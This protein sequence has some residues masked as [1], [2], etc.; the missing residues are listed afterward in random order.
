M[1]RF[2][3]FTAGVLSLFSCEK[4]ND[5]TTDYDYSAV[6]FAHQNQLRTVVAAEP[7]SFEFGVY[8]AGKR[9]NANEEWAKYRIEPELLEDRKIVGDRNFELIPEDCYT[10]SSPDIFN[11]HEGSFLGTSKITFDIEKFT[12]LPGTDEV[13]YALPVRVYETSADSIL[14]GKTSPEGSIIVA[15]MD[16]A[17]IAVRYINPYHGNYYIKGTRYIEEGE[18][19]KVDETYDQR[20]LSKNKVISVSTEDLHTSVT[21]V[22]G[23]MSSSGGVAVGLSIYVSD[24]SE[25]FLSKFADASSIL[26]FNDLGSSYNPDSRTFNLKYS[27]STSGGN[28]KVE[29]QLIW[30]DTELK[31]EQW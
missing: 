17:V 25:V 10:L 11:I 26:S 24:G 14:V 1:N 19:Y 9:E 22:A 13:R 4:W 3:L 31:F 23:G 7:M 5:Y 8:L 18:E 28:Y 20:D 21:K 2:I 16:Y 29:E 30:R 12:S 15:P 6:Y 27:F